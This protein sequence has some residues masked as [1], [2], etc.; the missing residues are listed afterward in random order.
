M[1]QVEQIESEIERAS[2]EL[3]DLTDQAKQLAEDVSAKNDEVR[4]LQ[5]QLELAKSK[6]LAEENAAW[7]SLM[8]GG[9]EAKF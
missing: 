3:A 8:K 4:N 2:N 9:Y 7:D 1:D 5:R 6:A